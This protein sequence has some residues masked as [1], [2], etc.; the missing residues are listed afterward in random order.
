MASFT[1]SGPG[2]QE[3]GI[4]EVVVAP[5]V[6]GTYAAYLDDDTVISGVGEVFLDLIPFMVARLLLQGGRDPNAML[7]VKLVGADFL[8]LEA[9]LSLAARTPLLNTAPSPPAPPP[10]FRVL[11]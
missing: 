7:V 11:P 4:I 8:M 10:P 9:P 3:R 1:A 2:A 6:D 5:Q